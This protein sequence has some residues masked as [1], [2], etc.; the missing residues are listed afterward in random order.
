MDVTVPG[1]PAERLCI[2]QLPGTGLLL[3]QHVALALHS[4]APAPRAARHALA[5]SLRL[6]WGKKNAAC[7]ASCSSCWLQQGPSIC[8]PAHSAQ[9]AALCVGSASGSFAPS[10]PALQ[11]PSCC[12]G[13][14]VSA[15]A[16]I[17][18]LPGTKKTNKKTTQNIYGLGQQLLEFSALVQNLQLLPCLPLG[19]AL[20]SP[21]PRWLG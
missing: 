10:K 11:N 2:K 18:H 4:P 9:W 17:N 7:T 8:P 13:V 3:M 20:F 5:A 21:L 19:E 14:D 12:S 16:G 15:K 6:S 1:V